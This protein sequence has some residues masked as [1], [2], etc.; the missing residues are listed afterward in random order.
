MGVVAKS[1]GFYTFDGQQYHGKDRLTEAIRT[2]TLMQ[3][4]LRQAVLE[5]VAANEELETMEG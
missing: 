5:V 2:D 1:G 4:K 3:D